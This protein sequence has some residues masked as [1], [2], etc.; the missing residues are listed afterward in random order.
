MKHAYLI[1]FAIMLAIWVLPAANA[2]SKGKP[3][4]AKGTQ[5][6]SINAGAKKTSPVR[7]KASQSKHAMMR[8]SQSVKALESQITLARNGEQSVR[9]RYEGQSGSQARNAIRQA[10]LE[11]ANL[12]NQ[13]S[14]AMQRLQSA[15]ATY[16]Q[17]KAQLRTERR[18]QWQNQTSRPTPRPT[19]SKARKLTFAAQPLGRTGSGST[20][21]AAAAKGILKTS[22]RYVAPD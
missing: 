20:R 7:R 18:I 4:A 10:T 21:P 5:A 1:S 19:Q 3:T 6:Q 8:A 16:R 13:Y 15:R 12:E 11:R 14:D 9:R 17:A 2:A 22:S